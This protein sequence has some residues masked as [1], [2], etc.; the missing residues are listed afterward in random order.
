MTYKSG[1]F[2]FSHDY[3]ESEI[4][5]LLVVAHVLNETIIDLPILP[6]L[7]DRLDPD[8]MYSSISGTAAIEGN[9]ITSDDA[10]KIS[11]G[12]NLNEYTQKHKQEILNLIEAYRFL[13]DHGAADKPVILSEDFIKKLHYTIT[14]DVYDEHNIPG[15]YRNGKVFVGDK[16]HGGIYTPPKILKDIKKLMHVFVTWINSD[17]LIATDPFIRGALCHYYL[18]LIHPFWDGNG[19]TA[20]LLEATI[21]QTANIRYAPQKLSN[22]YYS[23]VDDYY[24][25]FSKSIDLKKSATPF[26]RFVLNAAVESLTL[27]KGEIISF[28]RRFALRDYYLHMKQQKQITQRQFD[29]LNLLLDHPF[30]FTLK[31]LFSDLPFSILYQSVSVQTARRDLKKLKTMNFL[32]LDKTGLYT[33]NHRALG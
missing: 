4:S 23:S 2:Y 7:A 18:C 9:P 11:Q 17:E 26:I 10:R 16:A 30:D 12:Q 15:Q 20:R 27:I 33:L 32:S 8:L 24:I 14:K 22:Y 25:A 29:L 1:K 13:N 5:S 6:E 28:I 19:R 31:S 3:D 21:L